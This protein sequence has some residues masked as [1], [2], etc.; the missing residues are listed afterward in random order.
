MDNIALIGAAGAVG[1]SIANALRSQATPYR[2]IG[3]SAASLEKEFGS[4]PLA[5]VRT[6]NPEDGGTVRPAL[7]GIHTAIYLVGVNYW[8]FELHPVLMQ[9]T[10]NGAVA[11]G[12]K[13]ILL[14]GTVYPYGRPQTPTVNEDHPRNP[15]TFKGKKRKEQEDI[16]FA[17]HQAGKIQACEL[18]LPDFYGPGVEKSFLWSAFVAARKGGR[19]QL[20]GPI[21]TPHQFVFIPDVGQIVAQ[22]LQTEGAWGHAWNF[23][24]SGTSTQREIVQKIFAVSG[25]PAKM[26]VAGKTTL[27]L[28]GLFNP[29]M[30]EM[31]EMHYLQTDPVL[32]DD[33]R[34]IKL[35]GRVQR[36]SYEDGIRRTLDALL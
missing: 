29:L 31:V 33:S 23:A 15:H 13:R 35:L 3:R 25:K 26:M 11:A 7:D 2:V 21:D 32:L 8:Q 20:V 36:T 34:L 4:D 18:R 6:W 22:M 28:M 14:I 30:R 27:R 5:V 16:L 24:G 10:I 9:R 19:A 17:A 12:V 1:K